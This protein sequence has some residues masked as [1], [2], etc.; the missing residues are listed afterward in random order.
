M[1]TN[2]FYAVALRCKRVHL[3]ILKVYTRFEK[4]HLRVPID[5]EL[6]PLKSLKVEQCKTIPLEKYVKHT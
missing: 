5:T 6:T 1:C 4:K 2:R 3:R